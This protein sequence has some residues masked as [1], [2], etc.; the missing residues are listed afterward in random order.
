M[1]DKYNEI[2]NEIEM[3]SPTSQ[4]YSLITVPD[5]KSLNKI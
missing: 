5:N 1:K 4:N 3:K 2:G